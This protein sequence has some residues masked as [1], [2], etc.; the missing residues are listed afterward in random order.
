MEK[1]DG[2]LERGARLSYVSTL[3]HSGP[4]L[5]M[6][7]VEEQILSYPHLSA[8]RK[9]AVEAYV[10]ANPEW[11]SLLQDVRAFEALS[12]DADESLPQSVLRAYVVV[13]HVEAPDERS[14]ALDRAIDQIEEQIQADP[15]LQAQVEEIRRRVRAAE[16]A[17]D[18]VAHVEALTGIDVEEDGAPTV[19]DGGA[20]YD[21]SGASEGDDEGDNATST[22]GLAVRRLNEIP[23]SARKA[24]L[25][26]LV[27]L[28][29]YLTLAAASRLS[30]TPLDRLSAITVDEQM[31]DNYRRIVGSPAST[32][33]SLTAGALYMQTLSTLR[34]A[35]TS[36]LGLFP[37]Y[38]P[39]SLRRGKKGLK[40]VIRRTERHS[41]LALE[42]HFYLG[43]VHLAERDLDS[44]RS[45]FSF[46]VQG[47]GR[48]TDDARRILHA[49]EQTRAEAGASS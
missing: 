22:V 16:D 38:N 12:A 46:V 49:L 1:G 18:P 47:E 11:A 29:G 40:Q 4:C 9:R 13:A 15:E 28:A 37:Y 30:Q 21:P 45:A 35:R 19:R 20:E 27:L 25:V 44:A 43:K 7:N 17:V 5:Y 10:E 6:D 26:L 2:H 8:D 3:L 41:F 33:D 39:D 23:S 48:R 24:G 42:A 36:T 31:L 14:A 32:A 34:H